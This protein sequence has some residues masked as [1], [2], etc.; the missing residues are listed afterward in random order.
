MSSPE[1]THVVRE[2]PG[3]D[4]VQAELSR[5]EP[6]GERLKVAAI[7]TLGCLGQAA[8]LQEAVDRGSSAHSHEFAASAGPPPARVRPP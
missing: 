3:V 1:L 5:L 2:N 4:G 7:R 6:C 8:V